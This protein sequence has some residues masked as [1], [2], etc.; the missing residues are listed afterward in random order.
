MNHQQIL[1]KQK[2]RTRDKYLLKEKYEIQPTKKVKK[3]RPKKFTDLEQKL[4]DIQEQNMPN[5]DPNKLFDTLKTADFSEFLKEDSQ[6]QECPNCKKK[7]KIYCADCLTVL[8][9]PSQIPKV[10]LPFRLTIVHHDQEKTKKSSALPVKLLIENNEENCKIIHYPS[11]EIPEF[12]PDTTL[13]LYPHK[14]STRTLDLDL[15]TMKQIKNVVAID[16]T[17]NQTNSIL[18]NFTNPKYKYVRLEEYNT[19][20][21]RYQFHQ[22]NCLATIEAIYYFFKEFDCNFSSKQISQNYVYDGKYDNLMF[23]YHWQYEMIQNHYKYKTSNTFRKIKDYIKYNENEQKQEVQNE[24]NIE[25]N[26][27]QQN[28]ENSNTEGKDNE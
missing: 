6:R 24:Q 21:W 8:C 19:T 27:Q 3:E 9:E 23:F 11:H 1:D 5:V 2:V 12:D 4:H 10:Q 15:E 28:N 14:D 16:C 18:N 26:Q 17:W 7:S 13:I 20:F 25:Q 22:P